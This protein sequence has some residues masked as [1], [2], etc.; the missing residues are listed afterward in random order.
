MFAC[1]ETTR[2]VWVGT[3]FR[4][5]EIAMRSDH[6]VSNRISSN[7]IG[8]G[9]RSNRAMRLDAMRLLKTLVLENILIFFNAGCKVP[10]ALGCI[11]SILA[12]LDAATVCNYGN[13]DLL[14]WCIEV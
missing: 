14:S 13:I 8:R 11:F 1:L 6:I 7:L 9:L 5:D 2:A 12:S 4:H 3:I 10:I